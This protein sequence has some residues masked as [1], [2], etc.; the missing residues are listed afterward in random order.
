MHREWLPWCR[1]VS[2]PSVET[3]L[4]FR[5]GR[6]PVL[7]RPVFFLIPLLGA[8]Q[9]PPVQIAIW[10]VIVFFSVLLHELGHAWAMQ[11]FGFAPSVELHGMG[12]L[13]HWPRGAQPTAAMNLAVSLAGPGIQLLLGVAVWW[14]A[15]DLALSQNVRFVAGQLVWVNIGWA[16]VNLLPILPWDGGNSLDAF[17]RVLTRSQLRNKIVGGVSM[18]GGVAA[19]AFALEKRQVLFGYFGLMGVV[20]GWRRWQSPPQKSFSQLVAESDDQTL[21]TAFE[22]QLAAGDLVSVDHIT[23]QLF[24][25]K[26]YALAEA[27]LRE[28]VTRRHDARAA[29]NLACTLCRLERLDE[30]EAALEQAVEL[31]LQNPQMLLTDEDLAPLRGRAD[32]QA[33]AAKVSQP[34][35]P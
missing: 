29:Y 2:D 3:G 25:Q 16:L 7:V 35:P 5:L 31:G 17:I 20:H 18:V 10:A 9:L 33:L 8:F 11:A 12:G 13:T 4:K 14:L 21:R 27:L 23:T 26:R 1:R 28:L 22:Q 6:V 15:R 19:I 30:A 34:P 32:F 24:G